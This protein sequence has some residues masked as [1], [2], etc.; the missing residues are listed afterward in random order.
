[1]GSFRLVEKFE[2]PRPSGKVPYVTK[3]ATPPDFSILFAA[4][5]FPSIV[6]FDPHTLKPVRELL[7]HQDQITDIECF[8]GNPS[9]ALSCGSD[10]TA[11][12]WDI[13]AGPPLARTLECVPRGSDEADQIFSASIGVG[14]SL[15]AVG[16]SSKIHLFDVGTGKR[17]NI[18]SEVHSSIVNYVRFHPV[19]RDCI[20]SAADDNLICVFDSREAD[21]EECLRC[22][23]NNEDN[24][25]FFSFVGPDRTR[26][27]TSSM[28]ET[29]RIWHLHSTEHEING[30]RVAEHTGVRDHPV[31]E[32]DGSWGYAVDAYWDT[33]QNTMFTLGGSA[34]GH[35]ALLTTDGG[36]A[37]TFER[38]HTDVV[39]SAVCTGN[40][41]FTGG[42]DGLLCAWQAG[43]EVCLESNSYAPAPRSKKCRSICSPY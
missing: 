32:H 23:L 17:P 38:G 25:R 16:V 40:T 35:L 30:R 19:D 27:V 20:V 6:Q 11:R 21:E 34:G 7:G 36:M 26:L 9:V 12:V 42:E 43:E 15:A 1:M 24:V 29:L 31:L 14:D 33:K 18:Y 13:R 37:A 41:F 10:G 8:R 2:L 3:V 5:S 4:T 22:V 28:T 39:R